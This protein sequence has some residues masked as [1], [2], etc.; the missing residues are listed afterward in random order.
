VFAGK[1]TDLKIIMLSETSQTQKD[2]Y[3]VLFSDVESEKKKKGNVSK[4]R[5]VGMQ[6]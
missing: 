3:H 4:I 2:K 5:T 6:M 1:W